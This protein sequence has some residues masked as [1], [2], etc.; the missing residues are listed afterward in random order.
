MIIALHGKKRSGKDQF[1]SFFTSYIVEKFS[2]FNVYKYAFADEMKNILSKIY[3]IPLKKFYGDKNEITYIKWSDLS[4]EVQNRKSDIIDLNQYLTIRQLLQQ[5]GH[6]LR[7]SWDE[8]FWISGVFGKICRDNL[9]INIITDIRY[10][11]EL[12][13][14]KS[15]G[16]VCIKIKRNSQELDNHISEEGISESFFDHILDVKEGLERYQKQIYRFLDQNFKEKLSAYRSN[17][18][19]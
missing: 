2:Y 13:Y 17:K 15:E 5:F 3:N 6:G 4:I 12:M 14:C 16:A 7:L 11:N 19:E 1:A 18:C 9:N 8:N 10:V